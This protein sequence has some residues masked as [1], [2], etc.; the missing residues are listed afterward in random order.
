MIMATKEG[1]KYFWTKN[2]QDFWR[3]DEFDYLVRK[4]GPWPV[5]L[6]FWLCT[7]TMNTGGDFVRR[8]GTIEERIDAA[9]ISHKASW[10]PSEVCSQALNALI[11]VGLIY[12]NEE[13]MRLQI[14]NFDRLVGG[15]ETAE[16]LR[17]RRQR[18]RK[19]AEQQR[20][21]VPDNIPDNVTVDKRD[22]SSEIRVSESRVADGRE[23][24]RVRAYTPVLDDSYYEEPG[25]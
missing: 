11:E 18:D 12:G 23:P 16:A 25:F 22:K 21:I 9:Y 1:G 17:K 10:L 6:Y 19:R 5:V 2:R 20:D 8:I 15:S 4:Y 3:S 13:T 14:A 24:A 7:E